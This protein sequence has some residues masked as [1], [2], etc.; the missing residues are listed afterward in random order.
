MNEHPTTRRRWRP[1]ILL[2]ATA[3]AAFAGATVLAYSPAASWISSYNQSLIVS[4]YTEDVRTTQPSAAEQLA[5]A[6]AY[7]AALSSGA[8]VKA[9]SNIPTGNGTS[10]DQRF[11][12]E[13]LLSTP[14][15]TMARIQVP[16]IGVDLPIYHGTSDATL[17]K[18]A[19]HL[20]GTSLPVGG[21]NTHAVIT[22][23]RG[24]AD[25]TMFTDLDKVKTGDTFII[26][27]FGKV[28]TYRVVD[29]RVVDPS[30]TTTLRQ[31]AGRDLV[32][33]ITCTPLGINTQRILVTGQR[34]LPTPDKDAATA[35]KPPVL[36]TFPWWLIFYLTAIALISIYLWWAGRVPD[37][38]RRTGA[39]DT[40]RTLGG[41]AP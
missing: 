30:D 7:N 38:T 33:L 29:T 13:K 26:T 39:V 21:V 34:V 15:G 18:G 14:N 23:H 4:H 8:L 17:A 41:R 3:V 22:A 31:E 27:T 40:A 5:E 36:V 19:G 35:A 32:T 37:K 11:D 16:A 1:S 6:R 24:L 2:I 9:N 25:A 20:E 12:Y 28:L 10:S